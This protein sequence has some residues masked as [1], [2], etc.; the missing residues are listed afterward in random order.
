M[1]NKCKVISVEKNLFRVT[2][3]PTDKRY[4]QTG[5]ALLV[6]ELDKCEEKNIFL[7]EKCESEK[8]KKK[9]RLKKRF[10][11]QRAVHTQKEKEAEDG[12]FYIDIDYEYCTSSRQSKSKIP[13]SVNCKNENQATNNPMRSLKKMSFVALP[14]PV[15]YNKYQKP[16]DPWLYV[17]R[18][19]RFF[20]LEKIA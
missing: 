14:M 12:A 5:D 10:I 3:L 11:S 16:Q 2:K 1:L 15:G 20:K 13:L 17:R 9:I 6:K 7:S 8:P 4:V 19:Q 18:R